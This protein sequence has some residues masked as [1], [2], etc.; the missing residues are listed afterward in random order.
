MLADHLAELSPL[1]WL[2]EPE[3]PGVRYLALRDPVK[4]PPDAP[5]LI[6]ACIEA[7]QHGP[8]AHVLKYM[9]PEGF[10]SKPGP[11]YSP[12]YRSTVWA[13]ILLA[14]L[15][16]SVKQDD[17]IMRSCAYLLDNA[18]AE[19]GYF[20]YNGKPSGTI[21][22]LQG[23]LCWALTAL[24]YQD[25]RLTEAYEWMARSVTGEGV[26]PN[27]DKQA[28]VRYFTYTCGPGFQCGAN[29]DLPCSWGAAKVM[30]AFGQLQKEKGTDLIQRAI[31]RGVDFIFSV[32]PTTASWPYREKIHSGWWK[33]GF[34]VYYLADLLQVAEALVALG[35]GD[36]PRLLPLIQLIKD[37]A[38]E[39]GR[40]I[41]E[42][43]YNQ[44]TWGNYG[45]RDLPNKWVTLRAL[46][47]LDVTC[48]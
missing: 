22:C 35:Y 1:E 41:L 32:E 16:A 10:W 11:G 30:M 45:A 7:H 28:L 48:N 26:A 42:N 4:L 17:R 13:L 15:G 36:D 23:N 34:P 21:A 43:D 25:P 19:G 8:I 46:R 2:L 20:S 14:Q 38:N 3:D 27:K 31:E 39:N 24:G 9:S 40:W 37:K 5:E 18:Y 33:F 12:K 47:V 44:K 6:S 29:G